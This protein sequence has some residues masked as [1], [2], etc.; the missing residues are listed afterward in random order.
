MS[1]HAARRHRNQ[2]RRHAS[3]RRLAWRW[4]S[5]RCWRCWWP[6]AG[7]RLAT[8]GCSARRASIFSV[9]RLTRIFPR[10]SMPAAIM[11]RSI[12]RAPTR[13]VCGPRSG[14]PGEYG[15]GQP[16]PRSEGPWA[17]LRWDDGWLLPQRAL[18][19]PVERI[20]RRTTRQFDRPRAGLHARRQPAAGWPG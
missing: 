4:R 16:A 12:A 9:S 3:R 8:G 2:S 11:A 7:R 10:W 20:R 17:H 1:Q 13:Q 15:G 19:R 5:F 14:H 18:R 6:D